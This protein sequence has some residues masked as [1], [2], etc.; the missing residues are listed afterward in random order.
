MRTDIELAGLVRDAALAT[1][2]VAGL[3]H[4]SLSEAA[5]Y[6]LGEK[7]VGVKV[8]AGHVEVHVV[9]AYPSG[10]PLPELA[11]RLRKRIEPLIH[12]RTLDLVVDDLVAEDPS[13]GGVST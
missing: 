3:G 13:T 1:A 11:T 12:R 9:A 4:G 10:F 6:W 8:D 7:V 5:T 2:G